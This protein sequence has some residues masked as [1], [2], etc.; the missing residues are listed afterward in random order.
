MAELK[1]CPICGEPP[2]CDRYHRYNE[3]SLETEYRFKYSCCGFSSGLCK[4][5][6]EAMKAWNRRADNG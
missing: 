1:P 4:T 2:E 3:L 6:E 5:E